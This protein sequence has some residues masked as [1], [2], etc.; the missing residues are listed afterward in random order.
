MH[1][2]IFLLFRHVIDHD[3]EIHRAHAGS[4]VLTKIGSPFVIKFD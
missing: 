2:A 1:L 4:S 3:G